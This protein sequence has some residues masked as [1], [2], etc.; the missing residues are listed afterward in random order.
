MW[1]YAIKND[2]DMMW[3]R[4]DTGASP[5]Q[6]PKKVGNGWIFK[7]V[8]PA[9]GNSFYALTEDGKLIWYRHDGGYIDRL[10][11]YSKAE[12][13]KALGA[14]KTR[15]KG[16]SFNAK[17]AGDAGD[18]HDVFAEITADEPAPNMTPSDLPAATG[19]APIGEFWSLRS[20]RVD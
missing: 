10:D 1:V 18:T 11:R 15:V 4:K 3:Y 2:G 8:I 7:D 13:D 9:G 5:W 17:L 12:L 20:A 14:L 6:G 19:S 16:T